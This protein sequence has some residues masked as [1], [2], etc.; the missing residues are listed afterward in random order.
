MKQV[1]IFVGD[2]CQEAIQTLRIDKS[3]DQVINEDIQSLHELGYKRFRLKKIITQ[4]ASSKDGTVGLALPDLAKDELLT[5]KDQLVEH[6][7]GDM[8][9]GMVA[10]IW[11]H[12]QQLDPNVYAN[13]MGLP[14]D[15]AVLQLAQE[16][17]KAKD[18]K[19]V[20]NLC[21]RVFKLSRI[22]D[23]T[24]IDNWLINSAKS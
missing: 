10:V 18:A 13:F 8:Y 4:L 3:V 11:D 1:L 12:Q 9:V 23:Q 5:L 7:E 16:Q 20:Q 21:Q 2:R 19:L 24:Y 6:A 22:Q 15:P 14:E 17:S